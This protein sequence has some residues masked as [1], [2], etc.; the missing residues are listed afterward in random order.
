MGA[1]GVGGWLLSR[2]TEQGETLLPHLARQPS[3]PEQAAEKTGRIAKPCVVQQ[4]LN[5]RLGMWRVSAL[6]DFP[7]LAF[8]S[9]ELAPC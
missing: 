8:T 5:R 9:S 2:L 3:P 1:I 7:S 4:F 6:K